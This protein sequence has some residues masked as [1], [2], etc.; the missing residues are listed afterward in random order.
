MRT[1]CY[2]PLATI[3]G[4]DGFAL[5]LPYLLLVAAIACVADWVRT[6]PRAATVSA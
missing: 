5:F 6:Q 3:A 4:V 2:L 1:L